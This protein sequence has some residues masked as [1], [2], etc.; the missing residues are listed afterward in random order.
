M[1]YET[2]IKNQYHFIGEYVNTSNES[3]QQNFPSQKIPVTGR[4]NS[5]N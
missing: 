5:F 2:G 1:S 3:P 4:F